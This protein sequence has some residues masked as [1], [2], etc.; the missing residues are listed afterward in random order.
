MTD[1]LLELSKSPLAR[2]LVA[3]AN[4]PIPMPE[5]LERM[6]GPHSRAPR[7]KSVFV[8]GPALSYSSRARSAA[9]GASSVAPIAC[10]GVRLGR[11]G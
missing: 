11:R 2:R 9:A 6:R 7:G 4:L 3:S 1:V 10:L 5:S 8:S